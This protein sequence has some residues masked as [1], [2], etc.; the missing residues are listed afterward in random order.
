M[1][2]TG[3]ILAQAAADLEVGSDFIRPLSEWMDKIAVL[4]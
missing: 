2:I 4:H 1:L 3:S